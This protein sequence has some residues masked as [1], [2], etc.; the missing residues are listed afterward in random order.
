[1]KKWMWIL[2]TVLLLFGC[3]GCGNMPDSQETTA[4]AETASLETTQPEVTEP[5]ETTQPEATDPPETT[6]PAI[7][8]PYTL[9]GEKL[10]R[11]E[12]DWFQNEFFTYTSQDEQG[13][14]LFNIRNMFL[15]VEFERPEEINLRT[16]F[17]DGVT[18]F[19]ELTQEEK[20][21]YDEVTKNDW[22]LDYSK[23]PR[24]D[25]ERLFLENT[26]ITID[27]SL[28]IGLDELVYLEEFDA[29]Y[30]KAGDT[31]YTYWTMHEGVRMEDGKIVLLYSKKTAD[32][33]HVCKVT[34]APHGD[35]Y[36]F[37]SND[38]RGKP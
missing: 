22:P 21:R 30:Y 24:E 28:K 19:S 33:V 18:R 7:K 6:A 25:M 26:G 4:P 12:L 2:C 31:G 34:L 14:F 20:D 9:E 8:H 16:L 15:R 32:D 5:L 11:E 35:S 17:R 13:N 3:V 10:T 38:R 1:M 29:Y 27:Q 36:I 23:T 37:V